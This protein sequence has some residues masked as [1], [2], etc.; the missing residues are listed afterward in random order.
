MKVEIVGGPLDGHTV[1][2]ENGVDWVSVP[3]TV[4]TIDG[5]LGLIPKFHVATMAIHD[6]G[7]AYWNERY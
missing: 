4:G 1:S 6:D 5:P 3:I 2:V 7:K